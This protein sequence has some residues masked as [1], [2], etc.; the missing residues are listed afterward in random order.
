MDVTSM[1][2]PIDAR[3]SRRRAAWSAT[4]LLPA[5]CLAAC[6]ADEAPAST[7]EAT[8]QPRVEIVE[9][10]EAFACTPTRVWDGDGPV[11][12]AEGP[13][14]RLSGIA[15]REMDGSCRPGHPCPDASADQA[16]AALVALLGGQRGKAREGHALV[17]GPRLSCRS[18]GSA[19]GS[20]TAA[21]CT[22]PDGRD[23]ACAMIA[24]GTV[25][26][27]LRYDREGRL[28]RC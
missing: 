3:A 26:R 13:R 21:W 27:W 17:D 20:R 22:L 19:R 1:H 11:W 9:Q 16:K 23:L 10:G 28:V 12:C 2:A 24:T 7:I 18:D 5:L 15:A 25:L 4:A 6:T 8:T 14:L